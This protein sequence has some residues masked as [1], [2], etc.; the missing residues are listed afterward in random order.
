[1]QHEGQIEVDNSKAQRKIYFFY[2]EKVRLVLGGTTLLF[3]TFYS[4]VLSLNSV[5]FIVML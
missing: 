3:F 5:I 1:M 2:D 4:Y